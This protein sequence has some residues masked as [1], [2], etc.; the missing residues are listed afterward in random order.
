MYYPMRVIRNKSFR[1]IYNIANRLQ[2]P[3]AGDLYSSPTYQVSELDL[4]YGEGS[5]HLAS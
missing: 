1:L 2:Y 5:G 3:I 4:F